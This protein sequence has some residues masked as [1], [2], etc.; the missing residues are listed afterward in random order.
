MFW[1]IRNVMGSTKCIPQN[2]YVVLSFCVC[3]RFILRILNPILKE[4]S[5]KHLSGSELIIIKNAL[6]DRLQ[7]LHKIK[8]VV[9]GIKIETWHRHLARTQATNRSVNSFFVDLCMFDLHSHL[10]KIFT[11]TNLLQWF[12]ILY[13]Q[14]NVLL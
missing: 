12:S 2:E 10:F 11:L 5:L 6:T 13:F 3:Y 4:L 8:I 7:R 14:K 9:V 1:N